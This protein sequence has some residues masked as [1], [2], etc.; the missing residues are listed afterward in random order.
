MVTTIRLDFFGEIFLKFIYEFGVCFVDN[1]DNYEDAI[2][3][4]ENEYSAVTDLVPSNIDS[5]SNF[6]VP[7]INGKVVDSKSF[8]INDKAEYLANL[9][10]EPHRVSYIKDCLAKLIARLNE[11]PD[12]ILV[13]YITDND[14][15]NYFVID[16][17]DFEKM[18]CMT[19]KF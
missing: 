3:Y 11:N 8:N 15:E 19:Y 2:G 18:K 14:D 7:M 9:C 16:A 5:F 4:F 10:G 17:S 1:R 13:H 12:S 6:F